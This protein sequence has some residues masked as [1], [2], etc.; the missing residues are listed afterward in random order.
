MRSLTACA[1]ALVLFVLSRN[2]EAQRAGY[3]S[4]DELPPDGVSHLMDVATLG[5]YA[6][7]ADPDDAGGLRDVGTFALRSRIYL[8]RAPNYCAGLDGEIGA[9]NSGL[10]YGVT[11]YL[12][13]L[14]ARWDA[15]NVI[16]LCGGA[17]LNRYGSAV[18]LAARFPAELSL[19]LALG[20]IRPIV[21]LTPAWTSGSDARKKGASPSFVDELEA[22]ILIRFVEQHRYWSRVSAG[23]G[24]ALGFSYREF[25]DTRAFVG[26]V[27]FEFA[28]ER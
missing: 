9:S 28:G 14:G 7:V 20:P 4:P 10:A 12:V 1:A 25:M 8:G 11:G 2:A 26:L 16:S 23:G 15:G 18:P 17:G 24:F 5:A 22:G 21:W 13:G 19:A 3:A 27:G 6:R